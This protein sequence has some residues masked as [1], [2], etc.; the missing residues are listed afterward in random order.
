MVQLFDSDGRLV[1]ADIT[2]T[3]SG[4]NDITITAS[5]ATYTVVIQ[6]AA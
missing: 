5:D 2:Q 6:G 4:E 3:T 1:L